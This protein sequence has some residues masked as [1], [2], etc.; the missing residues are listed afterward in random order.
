VLRLKELQEAPELIRKI[1]CP[2]SGLNRA[3]EVG[4]GRHPELSKLVDNALQFQAIENTSQALNTI[5]PLAVNPTELADIS[6][7]LDD[8]RGEDGKAPSPSLLEMPK[9]PLNVCT[10]AVLTNVGREF[11]ARWANL[12]AQRG[13]AAQQTLGVRCQASPAVSAARQ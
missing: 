7:F 5:G 4:Q 11:D 12:S 3:R 8:P 2:M 13:G 9:A 6:S 1:L 10:Q